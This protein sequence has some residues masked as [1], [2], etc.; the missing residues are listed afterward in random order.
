MTMSD[1]TDEQVRIGTRDVGHELW[2]SPITGY[3]RRGARLAE[4]RA[5]LATGITARAIFEPLWSCPADAPSVE[6]QRALRSRGFD[7]AGVQQEPGGPVI[8]YVTADSLTEGAVRDHLLQIP[9]EKLT[10]DA[11]TIAR[12]LSILK[13]RPY[14]FVLSEQE[15]AGIVTRADLNKPPVR[16][17]LFGLISLLEMHLGHWVKVTYRESWQ[18]SLKP[19]RVEAARRV[20]LLGQERKQDPP[21]LECLQFGD[22]RDLVAARPELLAK[23]CLG[24]ESEAR[25]VLREAECLR[26]LLAH[27]HQDLASGSDWEQIIGMVETVEK[28]V[29]KSDECVEDDA[30]VLVQRDPDGLWPSA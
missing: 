18:G 20:Q 25:H 27:G 21:L 2:T 28:V 17:Y 9:L 13:N 8:G 26:D 16:V 19:N 24:T 3:R 1:M 14:V 5:L 23:L 11:T 7:V 6:M 22:R 29:Q 12:L 10:S 4:L 30:K 15:V